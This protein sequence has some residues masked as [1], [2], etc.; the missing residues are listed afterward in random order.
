MARVECLIFELKPK[1]IR[2]IGERDHFLT[3]QLSY[4][5]ITDGRPAADKHLV[6]LGERLTVL[7]VDLREH[8]NFHRAHKIL[9]GDEC[10][11]LVRLCSLHLF[12]RDHSADDH[13]GIILHNGLSDLIHN[14][15]GSSRRHIFLPEFPV[16][17]HR[18]TADIDA[19]GLLLECQKCLLVIL[20]HIRERDMEVVLFLL[21]GDVKEAHLAFHDRLFLF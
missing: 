20:A 6:F 21:R 10:H 8:E 2:D 16:F 12:R 9:N 13:I 5:V 3:D 17:L 19:D 7:L 11:E 14:E 4:R 15:I 18:M 1:L